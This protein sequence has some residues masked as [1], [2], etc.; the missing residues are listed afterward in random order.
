MRV[1]SE[2]SKTTALHAAVTD[3]HDGPS[4][5]ARG[6][7]MT[8]SFI[9][10]PRCQPHQTRSNSE[11]VDAYLSAAMDCPRWHIRRDALC[12]HMRPSATV[13]TTTCD[14]CCRRRRASDSRGTSPNAR[15]APVAVPRDPYHVT[16]YHVTS[17]H[18][19]R[20]T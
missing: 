4:T 18:V 2:A 17:Y 1:Q 5:I 10:L 14:C 16:S 7:L 12:D 8:S 19:S 9:W 20:T 3:R 13:R 11:T 6:I 15:L